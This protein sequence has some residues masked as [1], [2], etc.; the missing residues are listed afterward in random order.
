MNTI[1][2]LQEWFGDIGDLE[3]ATDRNW[4]VYAPATQFYVYRTVYLLSSAGS[5][6]IQEVDSIYR[7]ELLI[8]EIVWRTIGSDVSR[9][10]GLQSSGEWTYDGAPVSMN[11]GEFLRLKERRND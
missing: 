4:R 1:E 6:Q 11:M 7:L 5:M 3:T 8:Q 10:I 9:R 2:L